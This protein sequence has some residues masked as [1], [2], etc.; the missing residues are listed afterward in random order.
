MPWHDIGEYDTCLNACKYCYANKRP[1]IAKKKYKKHDPD[2][3]ILIGHLKKNDI[4]HTA[5]QKSFL[6]IDAK[7]QKL[8]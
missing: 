1:H 8:I 3:P 5:N 4:I 2:S 6:K 7:Q